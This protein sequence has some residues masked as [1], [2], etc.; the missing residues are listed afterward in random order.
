MSRTVSYQI[1]DGYK[2]KL[3]TAVPIEGPSAV[4]KFLACASIFG[5]RKLLDWLHLGFGFCVCRQI[6]HLD[7]V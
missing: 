7:H 3:N 6:W 2:I 1:D 5:E 4:M